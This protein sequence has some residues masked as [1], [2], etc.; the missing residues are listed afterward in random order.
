MARHPEA[1]LPNPWAAV[2]RR[3]GRPAAVIGLVV[4]LALALSYVLSRALAHPAGHRNAAGAA[5]DRCPPACTPGAAVPPQPA[6]SLTSPTPSASATPT[7]PASATPTPG[8][9]AVPPVAAVPLAA[10]FGNTG[11]TD[12]DRPGA[13]NLD[14]DGYTLSAQALADTGAEPGGTVTAHGIRFTWPA[15]PPG[16]PDNALAHGQ[17]IQ[18]SGTGTRLAFLVTGSYGSPSGAGQVVYA[19]GT[20]QAYTITAPDWEHGD[21]DPVLTMPYRN[22][23]TG[24]KSDTVHIYYTAIPLTAGKP[25]AAVVLPEVGAAVGIHVPAMHV[26]AVSLS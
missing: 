2:T 25:V 10:A 14:G 13:G 15:A 1:G 19:D 24:Q 4:V 3:G 18:L 7:P 23:P 11:I 9:K 6:G 20:R 26:F 16:S 12:D 21:G 17:A 8:R 22:R 5:T